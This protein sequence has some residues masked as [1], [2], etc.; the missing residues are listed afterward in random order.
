QANLLLGSPNYMSP[1]QTLGTKD[2][3]HRTDLWSLGAI[4]FELI[5]GKMAF[6]GDSI[7]GVLINIRL[8]PLPVPTQAAPDLPPE[9]DVFFQQVFQR[10]PGHRFPSARALSAEFSALVARLGPRAERVGPVAADAPNPT[11]PTSPSDIIEVATEVTVPPEEC[12]GD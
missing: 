9:I 10:D 5:T 8:G 11:I 12:D 4:L 2:L 1:E 6:A 3:D 7:V